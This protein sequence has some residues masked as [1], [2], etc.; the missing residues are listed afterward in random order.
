MRDRACGRFRYQR[1]EL[2]EQAEHS[3]DAQEAREV[4][5]GGTLFEPLDGAK[6]ES[7]ISSELGLGHVA[8]DADAGEPG[9]EGGE[10]WV[11]R[12]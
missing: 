8:G 5:R 11:V 2:V 12:G 3:A 7:G 1:V 4:C 10:E 6:T 9:A